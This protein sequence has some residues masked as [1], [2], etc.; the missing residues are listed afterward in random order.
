VLSQA[1]VNEALAVPVAVVAL[2]KKERVVMAQFAKYPAVAGF[3]DGQAGSVGAAK[4]T[5]CG[6]HGES[7]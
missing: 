1:G 7:I 3:L 5:V 4:N 2:P 6:N